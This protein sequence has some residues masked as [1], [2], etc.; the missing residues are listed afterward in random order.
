MASP[1]EFDESMIDAC[2]PDY[3]KQG[4]VE[5]IEAIESMVGE[6]GYIGFLRGNILKY[7]W[8]YKQKN[9]VEDLHKAG[10]YLDWLINAEENYTQDELILARKERGKRNERE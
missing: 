1:D 10:V 5:C 2:G 7:V 9:G 4:D 8:R 3:Y 6:E